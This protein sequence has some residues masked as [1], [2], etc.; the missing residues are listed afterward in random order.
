MAISG[1][2]N[3]TSFAG[4]TL[5]DIRR[6]PNQPGVAPQETPADSFNDKTEKSSSHTGLIA[7]VVALAAVVTGLI[8]T[9][10]HSEVINFVKD[11]KGFVNNYVK[12]PLDWAATNLTKAY[13]F[14]AGKITG[15]YNRI[16]KKAE[17]AAPVAEAPPAS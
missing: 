4:L 16:F 9:K 8:L 10:K 5:D 1:I 2:K 17:A 14:T 3:T 11:Q 13:D 6:A 12:R 15:L 7:T